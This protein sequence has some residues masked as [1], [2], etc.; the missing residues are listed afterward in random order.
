MQEKMASVGM[1]TTGLAHEIKN[2]L[3]FVNNF[4][5]IS[6]ELAD[7]LN[8]ALNENKDKLPPEAMDYLTEILTDL[9]TNC[10]KI[11]DHG[12][13]ADNIVKNMLEH[14]QG[15]SVT[16]EI[17]NIHDL[18]E[19]NIHLTY[20][21]YKA[22]HEGFEAALDT[23]F[24]PQVPKMLVSPQTLSQAFQ[25]IL[26]NSFYAVQE[27]KLKGGIP[28]Y[29]PKISISSEIADNYLVIRFRDNGSGIPKEN[30][31]K[32]FEPFYTTK[33]TGRGNTGLGL[34]ICYDMIVKQ[35]KGDIAVQSV[36]GEYS[37][38]IVKLPINQ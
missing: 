35:H 2:P 4:S 13:R 31:R 21:S 19:E 20:E 12:I 23:V 38:F 36:V 10:A 18:L 8:Q 27:K 33:P 22:N 28:G 3:N 1:L 29:E 16:K 15:S 17:L 30:Y 34:S 24:A 11:H 7:E 32:I 14:S 25:A 26:N 9:K 37:E 5:D 6:I